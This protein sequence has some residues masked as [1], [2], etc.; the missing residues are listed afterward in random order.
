MLPDVLVHVALQRTHAPS[1]CSMWKDFKLFEDTTCRTKISYTW[2]MT[3]KQ[4]KPC[5]AVPEL[6][7][8][9]NAHGE[10]GVR[11]RVI[12]SHGFPDIRRNIV[13]HSDLLHSHHLQASF[14]FH[15]IYSELLT[16]KLEFS[17]SI[18]FW[19]LPCRTNHSV[20]SF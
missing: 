9:L 1:V 16:L 4:L 12:S 6:K 2:H 20:W 17:N 11:F 19:I 14:T 10:G 5:I 8:L 7:W 15:D 18:F 13:Y 3:F